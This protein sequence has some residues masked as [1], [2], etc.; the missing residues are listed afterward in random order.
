M[1]INTRQAFLR[2]LRCARVTPIVFARDDAQAAPPPGLCDVTRK[3]ALGMPFF[4]PLA[5]LAG[6][7]CLGRVVNRGM[8][9]SVRVNGLMMIGRA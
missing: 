8:P 5:P 2:R 7:Q 3:G 1:A 4:R 6:A 9:T